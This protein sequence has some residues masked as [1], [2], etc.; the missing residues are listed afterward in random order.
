MDISRSRAVYSALEIIIAL[1]H[2]V[3][4]GQQSASWATQSPGPHNEYDLPLSGL[5]LGPPRGQVGRVTCAAQ[6]RRIETL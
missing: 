5:V 4:I 2:S 6:A 1:G 3:S